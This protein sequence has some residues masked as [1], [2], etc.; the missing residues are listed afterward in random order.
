MPVAPSLIVLEGACWSGHRPGPVGLH[1]SG[2]AGRKGDKAGAEAAGLCPEAV[3]I[4]PAADDQIAVLVYG[5]DGKDA[6]IAW[7]RTWIGGGT[8]APGRR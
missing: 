7:I 2:G 5:F 8:L 4:F 6:E 3:R 1:L